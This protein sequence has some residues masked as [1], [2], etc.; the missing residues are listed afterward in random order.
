MP[1][2]SDIQYYKKKKEIQESLI[3]KSII[4]TKTSVSNLLKDYYERNELGKPEFKPLIIEKDS[5]SNPKEWNKNFKCLG[6]DLENVFDCLV[7]QN[8][9]V[10]S[11]YETYTY[12]S[13]MLS[14]NIKKLK[15]SVDNLIDT[16]NAKGN[17][18]TNHQ[19]FN[20]FYSTD[21]IGDLNRN[22]P[23]T[24]SFID[25][26]QK[27][28]INNKKSSAKDKI[29]LS[30]S[31]IKVSTNNNILNQKIIGKFENIL[32]DYTNEVCYADYET[33][34]NVKDIDIEIHITLHSLKEM[35]TILFE[36][37]SVNDFSSTLYVSKN[38]IDFKEV[39]TINSSSLFEWNFNRQEV[40]YIK[41]VIKKEC[42]D[43][44][45]DNKNIFNFIFKNISCINDYYELKSTYVSKPIEFNEILDNIKL[46]SDETIF[47]DTN[48]NYFIA[49][50]NDT[51]SLVWKHIKNN[52][53]CDLELLMDNNKIA[54]NSLVEYGE[55]C[56]G[57]CVSVLNLK[58][59]Y[60]KNSINVFYGYQMWGVKTLE[61]PET[62]DTKTYE[63]SIVDYTDYYVKRRSL[64]D[65]EEYNFEI[66]NGFTHILTQYVYTD[67]VCHVYDRYFKDI[68]N[69]ENFTCKM[70]LNNS[71][72][73]SHDNNF[74]FTL[75]KGKNVIHILLYVKCTDRNDFTSIVHNFNFKEHTFDIFADKPM[76]YI[77]DKTL[78]EDIIENNN[79]YYS[80]YDN[81]IIVKEDM[82]MINEHIKL[83][84]QSHDI[85]YKNNSR[86]L[87]LYKSINPNKKEYLIDGERKTKIRIMANLISNNESISP[88][89]NSFRIV[90]E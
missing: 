1:T 22:I 79:T 81:K 20:D 9:K 61:I 17:L 70:Y 63:P 85:N 37:I 10:I 39:Y 12:E 59:G 76:T 43:G 5:V 88:K 58:E 64:I 28:V 42:N 19:T 82:R 67:R 30:A 41:I 6:D 54:N 55:D 72:I 16:L 11:N 24:D 71:L 49:L 46:I 25:L 86:Y 74:S 7:A 60:T 15:L 57:N 89:I 73:K 23:C 77:N 29:N 62:E 75:K 53:S 18:Y 65:T 38:N 4:P 2:I 47:P 33:T 45:V 21:F 36:C 13:D 52:S 32:N 78:I 34:L 68:S 44:Y 26:I 87:I 48:I 50:D 90:G 56:I 14:N 84:L 27:K 31:K 35:S 66:R 69:S 51:N 8:N 83:P 80:I 3:K 40:G